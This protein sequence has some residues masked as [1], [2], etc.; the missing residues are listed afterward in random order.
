[1][2][3][4][5]NKKGGSTKHEFFRCGMIYP[6]GEVCPRT[7]GVHRIRFPTC[8]DCGCIWPPMVL[9]RTDTEWFRKGGRYNHHTGELTLP[10]MVAT[11]AV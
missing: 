2:T 11:C 6:N 4:S 8:E 10:S 9:T 5:K 1:M 3:D 7:R